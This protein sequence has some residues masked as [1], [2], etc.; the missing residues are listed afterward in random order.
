MR[1]FRAAL[2]AATLVCCSPAASTTTPTPPASPS[3]T[4]TLATG[5]PTRPSLA[6]APASAT[7]FATPT[8]LVDLVQVFRPASTGWRPSGPTIIAATTDDRGNSTLV[9]IPL[10][11]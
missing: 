11:A 9:G 1:A 10:G 3:P 5:S 4:S 8:P 2:I 6:A 7:P